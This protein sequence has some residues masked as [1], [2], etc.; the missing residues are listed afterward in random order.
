MRV[1]PAHEV[2][3]NAVYF[4]PYLG[5]T[6]QEMPVQSPQDRAWLLM[7]L[8]RYIGE[9]FVQKYGGC[10]FVNDIAGSRYFARYV[11]GRFARLGN[12]NAMIDPFEAAQA[13]VDTPVPRDLEALLQEVNAGLLQTVDPRT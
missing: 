4:A 13:F 6:L 7:N 3:N 9:Y 11:A 10:W 12:M 1:E 5:R 2:L 8:A